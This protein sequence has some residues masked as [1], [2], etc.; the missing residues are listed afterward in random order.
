MKSAVLALC[1]ASLIGWPA[2]GAEKLIGT[3]PPEWQV[4]NWFNSVPLRLED[5]RGKVVLVRWWTAPDCPYCKATAPALN[6]FYETYHKRG[7]EVVGLYHHKSDQPLD[8]AEV[9]RFAR[10]FGFKFPNAIDADWRTLRSWWLNDHDRAWT[11]VS[12]L[13]DRRGIIRYIHPGGQYV[14]GD[15]D[16]RA[17]KQ[18][19]EELLEAPNSKLQIPEKIQIS[20]P[21]LGQPVFSYG[22]NAP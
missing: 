17:M 13:I 22:K 10:N 16:Y 5:L 6:E 2:A 11:S 15:T 12:F 19:I 7:L 9:T 14:K 18:K 4:T 1:V 3:Q 21:K 20:S 8:V